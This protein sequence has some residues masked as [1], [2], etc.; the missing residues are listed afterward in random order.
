[1]GVESTQMPEW[2]SILP[3]WK[4]YSSNS[5]AMLL[6]KDYESHLAEY[7]VVR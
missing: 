7:H 3:P 5:G 2:P 6:A 4:G 1:M